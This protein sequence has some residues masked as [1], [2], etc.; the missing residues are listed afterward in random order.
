MTSCSSSTF[1][2]D[3]A[4]LREAEDLHGLRVVPEELGHAYLAVANREDAGRLRIG[5]LAPAR[6]APPHPHRDSVGEVDV[7]GE[8]LDLVGVP[9]L[10][11]H[12]PLSNDRVAPNERACFG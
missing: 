3:I 2:R 5:V 8:Q 10:A 1:S 12:L 11:H 7:V 6:A 9:S 4:S